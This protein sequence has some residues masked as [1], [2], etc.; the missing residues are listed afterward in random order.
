MRRLITVPEFANVLRVRLARGYEL[1]RK[2][3]PGARVEL[4]RQIRIDE[5]LLAKWIQDGGTLSDGSEDQK[6][7]C[8][9]D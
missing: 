4:G 8:Q 6:S 9:A 7:E 5:D 1:A 3:P 2:L